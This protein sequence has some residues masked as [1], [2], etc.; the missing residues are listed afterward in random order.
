M[1]HQI[2]CY[3]FRFLAVIAFSLLTPLSV[4]FAAMDNMAEGQHA[5]D[6]PAE[7][8]ADSGSHNMTDGGH[9]AAMQENTIDFEKFDRDEAF[10]YS[11]AVIGKQVSNHRFIDAEG[12]SVEFKDFAGQPLLISL[13]YTSC[14]HICP[15]TTRYL[16][17][18]VADARKAMPGKQFTLLSIGFDTPIDTP[19]AMHDFQKKQHGQEGS[20]WHFLSADESTIQALAKELGF[21]YYP[22]PQGFNHL[23]QTS[24]LDGQRKIYRQV[25]GMKFEVPILVEPLKELLYNQPG[26]SLV[27]ALSDKVRFFCTVYD[28]SSD[29]Y[30]FDYSIFI[31]VFIGVMSCL[32]MGFQLVKEWRRSIKAS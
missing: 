6:M 9:G 18:V 14:Y 22:S 30:R 25:Y 12:R 7:D 10:Q 31:G 21:I 27:Q 29:N 8:G 24:I 5:M 1:M 26:A 4:S 16:G 11:Q 13:I 15:T 19:A 28:P 3:G 23:V 20:D 32:V 17:Q 2:V